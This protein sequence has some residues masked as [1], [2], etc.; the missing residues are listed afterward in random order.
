[1]KRPICSACSYGTCA[2]NYKRH[3]KT[4]FRSRCLACINRNKKKKVPIPRWA[5]SGYK[6]KRICDV[7]GFQCKHGSQMR[8]HHMDA[9]LNNSELLNLRSVCLNCTALIQAQSRGWKAG[10]LS[11]D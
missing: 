8:V 2:I 6:M 1:M 11:P 4:Y 3:G 9:N 5:S 7:C 10:D